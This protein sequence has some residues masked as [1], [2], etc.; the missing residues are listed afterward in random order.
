MTKKRLY[1]ETMEDIIGKSEHL[2]IVDSAVKGVLPLYGL[3]SDKMVTTAPDKPANP[4]EK[5]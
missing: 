5:K 3:S 1:L 4:V 2:I